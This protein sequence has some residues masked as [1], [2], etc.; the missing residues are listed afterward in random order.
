MCVARRA[1]DHLRGEARDD[2]KTL[3]S[4]VEYAKTVTIR[5]LQIAEKKER[6]AK[7]REEE[8]VRDLE[9]EIQRLEQ[10]KVRPT[11]WGAGT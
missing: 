9:V 8:R 11:S 3:N 10:I 1:A 6:E 5:N 4:L 2:V 7:A